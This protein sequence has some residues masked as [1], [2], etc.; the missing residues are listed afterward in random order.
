MGEPNAGPP[1]AAL[2]GCPPGTAETPAPGNAVLVAER[3]EG[4]KRPEVSKPAVPYGY[5]PG[6]IVA[7]GGAEGE[8]KGVARGLRLTAPLGVKD[9]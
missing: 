2:Q 1:R 9:S 3:R 7:G 5:R 8:G 6:P 4:S